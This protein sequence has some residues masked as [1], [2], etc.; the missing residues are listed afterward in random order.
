MNVEF[1]V[2]HL[3]VDRA[4]RR[5]EDD[6]LQR[7][8][9]IRP[10]RRPAASRPSTT[11]LF[12]MP[13]YRRARWGAAADVPDRAGDRGALGLRQ[14]RDGARALGREPRASAARTSWAPSGSSASTPIREPQV[15]MLGAARP[16]ARRD[17]AR[18]RRPARGSCCSTSRPPACPTR[19]PSTSAGVIRRIPEHMGALVILVDHDMSLVSA[20]ARSTAV[21][22]FGKLIAVR[23]DGRGAAQRAR[24]PGLPRHRGG[25]V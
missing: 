13:H 4:Q 19:R 12:A 16:P 7:A 11:D 18:G 2:G 8:E 5:G 25:S 23:P 17:R 14:R 3:R 22:D 1:P 9:R 24:H 20:A 10:A 21:L 15:G 6:V